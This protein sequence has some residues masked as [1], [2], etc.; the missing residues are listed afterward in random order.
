MK[1]LII[2]ALFWWMCVF[3]NS[4]TN[5]LINILLPTFGWRTSTRGNSYRFFNAEHLLDREGETCSLSDNFKT[6]DK[7]CNNATPNPITYNI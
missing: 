5:I 2:S 4:D 7:I 6:L 3:L 1:F